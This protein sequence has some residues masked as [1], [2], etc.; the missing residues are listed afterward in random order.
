MEM[1]TR[2]FNQLNSAQKFALFFIGLLFVIG[3]TTGDASSKEVLKI[4]AIGSLSGSGAAWGIATKN[5][6]QL[7]IDEVNDRGGL[8]VGGKIYELKQII[9]DDTYTGQ[10]GTTA[11][12]RLIFEDKV[13]FI[14]G[15]IGSPAALAAGLVANREKVLVFC[16][17]FSPRIIGKDKPYTFRITLSTN[18]FA[19]AIVKWMAEKFP[20]MR[21]VAVICTTDEVGQAVA[22][23]NIKYYKEGGFELV[24]D[25]R[26]ERGT[27]DMV[28]IINRMLIKNPDIIELDGHAP[29]DVALIVKQTRQ[30]GYKKIM[31]Q[32]GGPG[33]EQVLEVARELA[34]DFLSYNIFDPQDPNVQH[35]VKAYDKKFGGFINPY[36]PL[37]YNGTKLLFH[38]IEK[39]NTLDTDKIKAAFEKSDGYM[40]MMGPIKWTGEELY[41]IRHQILTPFYISQIKNGKIVTYTKIVP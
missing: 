6:V 30:L 10:G 33:L 17:G 36:C 3:I 15:P 32:T 1:F 20:T 29:G 26:Y 25:E 4:G 40:T 8:K 27:K 24:A 7:A 41:G 22:P 35:F 19:P 5:G 16:N 18:E 9:Y 38:T 31:I 12:N 39:E 11:A 23:L 13:N 21:K 28:P 2:Q 14:I 34:E 37:M